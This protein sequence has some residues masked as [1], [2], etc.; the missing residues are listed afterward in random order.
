MSAT[1]RRGPG[2]GARTLVAGFG[3]VLRGDDGFGVEVVRRLE[4]HLHE[5]APGGG[6]SGD[7]ELLEVGTGGI[8]LAQE[9]CGGYDRL[10]VVDAMQRGG[11]P[12]AVYV[13]A[14]EALPACDPR[15]AR[16]DAHLVVPSRALALARAL[17]VLPDD[18]VLVGCEPE[19]DTLDELTLEL[20]PR[21]S[22]GAAEAVRAVVRLLARPIDRAAPT[23]H[24]VVP[25][26]L[27]PASSRAG[28]AEREIPV[29]RPGSDIEIPRSARDDGPG[30]GGA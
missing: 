29:Y 20:S 6:T 28:E 30:E 1:R 2:G 11:A 26:A 5:T 7:V 17:G 24:P 19:P 13:L 3:N 22:A 15:D 12:G 27:V 4:A 10:I 9:L 14:V 25:S 16:V 23:P 8:R 18:V 21:A